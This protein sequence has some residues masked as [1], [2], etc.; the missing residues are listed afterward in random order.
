MSIRI[1]MDSTHRGVSNGFDCQLYEQGEVYDSRGD[2]KYF[3]SHTLAVHFI[4]K[5]FAHEQ[6]WGEWNDRMDARRKEI[7]ETET[8]PSRKQFLQMVDEQCKVIDTMFK[9]MRPTNPQTFKDI[10][11]AL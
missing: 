3:I 1:V 7:I 4:N 11:E 5:G 8:D 9:S 10:G 2:G 6:T